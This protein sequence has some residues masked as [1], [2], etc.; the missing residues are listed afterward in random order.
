MFACVGRAIAPFLM[1]SPMTREEILAKLRVTLSE[2][3]WLD[4]EGIK[5]ESTLRGDLGAESID[6]LD[7]L[8]RL[9]RNFC[10]RIP[11]GELFLQF[12]F[13][14]DPEYIDLQSGKVLPKGIE[15]I[16]ETVP[17]VKLSGSGEGLTLS[18]LPGVF[19]VGHIADYLE[20][21]LQQP[22]AK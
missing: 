5:E 22:L 21:K 18:D 4:P 13:R 1:E 20:W 3:F 10:I 9:E 2:S 8:F 7:I 15:Y 19:I 11:S 14:G 17:W 16:N 12:F 6:F